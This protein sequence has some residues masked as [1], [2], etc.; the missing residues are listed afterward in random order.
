[1]VIRTLAG[2]KTAGYAGLVFQKVSRL[3]SSIISE[4][5]LKI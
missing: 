5:C 2:T 4:W 1:M 3:F